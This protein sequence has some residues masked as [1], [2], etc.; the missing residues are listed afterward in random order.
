LIATRNDRLIAV[1]RNLDDDAYVKNR[2][3]QYEALKNNKGI[4]VAKQIV[5]AKILGQNQVLRKYGLRQLDVI[6]IK[7]KMNE[8][9]GNLNHVRKKLRVIKARAGKHYFQEVFKLFDKRVRPEEAKSKR[10]NR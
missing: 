3:S 8:M 2:I 4:C 5:L 10:S 9:D 7:A 6:R 1:L